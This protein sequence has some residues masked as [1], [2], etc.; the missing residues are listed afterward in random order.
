VLDA[1]LPVLVVMLRG[2][3]TT[4]VVVVVGLCW[5]VCCGGEVEVEREGGCWRK[6]A[7]KVERKK[8]RWEDMVLVL[9]EKVCGGG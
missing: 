4:V 1:A 2:V 7:K 5:W 6:A 8:G 3:A 9:V